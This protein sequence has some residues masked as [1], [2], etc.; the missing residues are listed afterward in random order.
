MWTF[1][2]LINLCFF[3]PLSVA[4]TRSRDV[5]S[6]G[7]PIPKGVTFPK[8]NVFRDF[9]LAKVINA[10]NAAH[11]SEKFRAMATRTRQEYLKDL[12]EKNVTNTPIDPS[13]KFPFIS[14][15]SKKKEKSKPYPGAEL[16]SMGAI[17]WAVRAKDY[18]T[19]MEIDCLL[20]ISNEF[21]VLIEQETKSV[22]FNCSCRDVIG[23]T[24]T[25]TSLKIFYERGE[26]V[27]V[28]SFISN[29]EIK[30]IVK[31]LQ[32]S[33]SLPLTHVQFPFYK[34]FNTDQSQVTEACI[35]Y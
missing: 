35:L 20:G 22:V 19:A 2:F 31:R 26:C 33:L 4:V 23:W 16:S 7:P 25:D 5:P 17:V 28:E 30:E 9:L 6:F 12:A 15:A 34:A 1:P 32:V 10:E 24:S 8:S 11:K 18:N 13:G 3:S 29:E 27:S 14:L 21:I